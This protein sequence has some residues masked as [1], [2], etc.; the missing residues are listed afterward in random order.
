M[1]AAASIIPLTLGLDAMRQLVFLRRALFLN[2]HRGGGAGPAVRALPGCRAAA[3]GKMER[4]AI[5]EGRLTE[6][7]RQAAERQA[8]WSA[9]KTSDSNQHPLAIS[10]GRPAGLKIESN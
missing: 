3:A 8:R 4:L 9:R 10:N 2:D 5:R 7:R 1:A 6:A